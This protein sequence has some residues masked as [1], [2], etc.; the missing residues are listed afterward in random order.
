MNGHLLARGL[1]YTLGGRDTHI[2]I[3]KNTGLTTVPR[4]GHFPALGFVEYLALCK[5]LNFSESQFLVY[6]MRIII[7]S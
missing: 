6:L 2:G 4:W 1:N 7:L 5:L 3:G